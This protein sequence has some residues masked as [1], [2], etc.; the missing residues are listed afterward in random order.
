MH[1][2][3]SKRFLDR[4]ATDDNFVY[5]LDFQK[6]GGSVP[7]L[8]LLIPDVDGNEEFLVIP[9]GIWGRNHIAVSKMLIRGKGIKSI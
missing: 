2:S 3:G 5:S 8:P 4:A 1:R 7:P 6:S 9:A